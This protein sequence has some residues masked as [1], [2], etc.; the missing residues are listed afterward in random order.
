MCGIKGQVIE[1]MERTGL[2][3]KIGKDEIYADS[4]AAVAGLVTKVHTHTDLPEKGCSNC[5]LTEFIPVD[6]N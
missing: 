3:N 6:T 5:P 2:Y 1:V 4:K